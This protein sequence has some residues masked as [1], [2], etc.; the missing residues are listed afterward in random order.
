MQPNKYHII[1]E[2]DTEYRIQFSCEQGARARKIAKKLL[3]YIYN[4]YIKIFIHNF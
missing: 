4:I 3:I 2:M 1:F